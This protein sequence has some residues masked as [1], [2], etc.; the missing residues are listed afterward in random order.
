M[1]LDDRNQGAGFPPVVLRSDALGT[2]LDFK[3]PGTFR[4]I[5]HMVGGGSFHVEPGEWTDDTSMA[6]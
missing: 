6:L 3:L 1:H 4:P 2:S 5:D